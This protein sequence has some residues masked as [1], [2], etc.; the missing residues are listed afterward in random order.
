M[1]WKVRVDW[2]QDGSFTTPGDDITGD[3]IG[4]L[5]WF[6]G[7]TAWQRAGEEATISLQLDN[8]DRKYSIENS[9]SSLYGKLK[10]YRPIELVYER[11]GN[12]IRAEY[13]NDVIESGAGDALQFFAYAEDDSD[14]WFDFNSAPPDSPCDVDNFSARFTGYVTPSYSETYMFYVEVSDGVRLWVGGELIIDKWQQ[15]NT[16]TERTSSTIA[17][18]AGRAYELKLEYYNDRYGGSSVPAI[19]KLRWSSA[20]Q[21]KGQIQNA[22][23]TLPPYVMWR[24]YVETIQPDGLLYASRRATLTAVG[25]KNRLDRRYATLI[26]YRADTKTSDLVEELLEDYIGSTVDLSGIRQGQKTVEHFGDNYEDAETIA[27]WQVLRDIADFEAGKILYVNGRFEFWDRTYRYGV[28]STVDE[29]FDNVHEEIDYRFDIEQIRNLITVT[30][31]ERRAISPGPTVVYEHTTDDPE[32]VI[33]YG[34]EWRANLIHADPTSGEPVIC[35]LNTLSTSLSIVSADYGGDHGSGALDVY[36]SGGTTPGYGRWTSVLIQNN[37]YDTVRIS[38]FEI[39]AEPIVEAG[40]TLLG[41]HENASFQT[42]YGVKSG[43]IDLRLAARLADAE[44]QAEMLLD[45]WGDP[46]P[47]AWSFTIR[48][49]DDGIENLAQLTTGI[50]ALINLKDDQLVHD[51]DYIIVGAEHALDPDTHEHITTYHVESVDP[52]LLITDHPVFGLLDENRA[53]F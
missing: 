21:A 47:Y 5:K 51:R 28:A 19:C 48:N 45:L 12:G 1:G 26:K 6:Q 16:A 39:T 3:V 41:E 38:A 46:D 13:Y 10:G 15:T 8:I 7:V 22:S 27:I 30:A 34:G 32:I 33:P 20:S 44:G 37:R 9:G 14:I 17:L 40:N 53:G 31:Y 11:D 23:L 24:G 49:E 2:D 43:D 4:A 18:T 29:T 52:G 25:E 35:N 36:V 42:A 50:G